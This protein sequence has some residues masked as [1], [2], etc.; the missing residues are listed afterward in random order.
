MLTKLVS[1]LKRGGGPNTKRGIIFSYHIRDLAGNAKKGKLSARSLGD[2]IRILEKQSE[3][4]VSLER[5]PY[6]DALDVRALSHYDA[7]VFF[8]ELEVMFRSGLSIQRALSVL[9]NQQIEMN[10]QNLMHSLKRALESGLSFSEALSLFPSIFPSFQIGIIKAG[11]KG[12][13]MATSLNQLAFAIEKEMELRKKIKAALEYPLTVF[14]L[15]LTITIG[16]FYLT[17][18]HIVA[19][20]RDLHI[21]LPLH[22]RALLDVLGFLGKPYVS[23]PLL[24]GMILIIARWNTLARKYIT[25]KPWW[26]KALFSAPFVKDVVRKALMTQN[27]IILEALIASGI[28]IAS[29]VQFVSETC[30]NRTMGAAFKMINENLFKGLTLGE[31]ME[32]FPDIFPRSVVSMVAIGEESGELNSM[33]GR[34]ISFNTIDLD[35]TIAS[36]TK[37]IEPFAI[38]ALGMMIGGVLLFFFVPIYSALYQTM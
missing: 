5:A 37:I 17:L 16:A 22:T 29:A 1:L 31:G 9:E 35:S 15:G 23:L 12:G 36:L 2:A 24:A 38:A 30:E 10:A 19:L 13:F 33:L 32:K 25:S 14:L 18:P 6:E 8:R 3:A 28:Q 34:I 21:A 7:M 20:I 4:I 26:E 11:E 27:F